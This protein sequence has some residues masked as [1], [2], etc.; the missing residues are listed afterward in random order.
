[1]HREKER[2]DGVCVHMTDRDDV[3]SSGD[4]RTL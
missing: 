3:R 1:M 4:V 2:E